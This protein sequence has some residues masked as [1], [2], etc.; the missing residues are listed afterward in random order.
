MRAC[1][2]AYVRTNGRA[3]EDNV[4]NY[5][6]TAASVIQTGFWDTHAHMYIYRE[7]ERWEWN[8]CSM[9]MRISTWEANNS[10][11]SYC[12]KT[13]LPCWSDRIY[14]LQNLT[15]LYFLPF[16]IH[17]KFSFPVLSL[18]ILDRPVPAYHF[19]VSN[20]LNDYSSSLSTPL[21]SMK[22]K[23]QENTFLTRLIND[24]ILSLCRS[25]PLPHFIHPSE[26]N[27]TT[28][29]INFPAAQNEAESMFAKHFWLQRVHSIVIVIHLLKK[30]SSLS[31][32]PNIFAR[33]V[34]HALETHINEMISRFTH[35]LGCILHI[36]LAW[37]LKATMV[38][39]L[40]QI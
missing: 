19:L 35:D 7:R 3:G 27:E 10:H 25:L 5:N 14:P 17:I 8:F 30:H 40:N 32:G 1:W 11:F 16:T 38:L 26:Q 29:E 22:L 33:I 6:G 24:S 37:D 4:F 18:Q 13:L 39:K 23:Y 12:N 28:E 15:F 20:W 31:V 34:S 9:G 21:T 2:L 36:E